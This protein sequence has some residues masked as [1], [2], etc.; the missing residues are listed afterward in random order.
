MIMIMYNIYMYSII[1]YR[2][3]NNVY[4]IMYMY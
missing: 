4:T 2:P 3:C 1:A